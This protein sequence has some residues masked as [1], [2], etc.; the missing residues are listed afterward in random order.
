[1][2]ISE[3]KLKEMRKTMMVRTVEDILEEIEQIKGDKVE[4]D[5]YEVYKLKAL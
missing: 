4:L 5:Y 3:D 1:M 2:E